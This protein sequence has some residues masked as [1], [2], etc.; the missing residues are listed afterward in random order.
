MKK[1]IAS[2]GTGAPKSLVEIITLGRTLTKRAVDVLAYFEITRTPPTAPP[3][4]S[5]SLDSA[6]LGLAGQ[7]GC[8]SF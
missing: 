1:L 5:V 7:D 4:R 2:V 6:G 3:R 8:W